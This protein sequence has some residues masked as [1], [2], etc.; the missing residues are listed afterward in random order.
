MKSVSF[1]LLLLVSLLLVFRSHL[2][3]GR[4]RDFYDKPCNP[5]D[6]HCVKPCNPEN[7]NCIMDTER[8]DVNYYGRPCNPRD[9]NCVKPCNPENPNC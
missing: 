3:Q 4:L 6:P 1:Q 5:M 2:V 8:V 7:P 9:P